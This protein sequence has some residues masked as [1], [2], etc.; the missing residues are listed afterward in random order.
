MSLKQ[1]L[2]GK[3]RKVVI[4]FISGIFMIEDASELLISKLKKAHANVCST[5]LQVCSV[6]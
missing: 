6:Q 2:Q 5:H 4:V 3:R 1:H